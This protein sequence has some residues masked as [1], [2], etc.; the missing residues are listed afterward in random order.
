MKH[1]G[2]SHWLIALAK[3]SVFWIAGS[4][5]DV[6]GQRPSINGLCPNGRREY[7]T[8]SPDPIVWHSLIAWI[9]RFDTFFILVVSPWREFSWDL[10]DFK[11][12]LRTVSGPYFACISQL[13][14]PVP[15]VWSVMVQLSDPK[16]EFI[17]MCIRYLLVLRCQALA[18][19]A[20]PVTIPLVIDWIIG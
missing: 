1:R 19:A 7:W 9:G 17:D 15:T 18:T 2:V 12:G 3:S 14:R 20:I 10:T 16:M 11:L 6:F 8:I 13:R 5:H 4:T